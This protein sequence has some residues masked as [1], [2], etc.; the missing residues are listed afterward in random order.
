MRSP[1]PAL[2]AHPIARPMS[3]PLVTQSYS[4][5]ASLL[6][7]G[8]DGDGGDSAGD[9]GNNNML[10]DNTAMATA[11]ATP[12]MP[13][14]ASSSVIAASCNYTNVECGA[15][16]SSL[17]STS[18]LHEKVSR[19]RKLRAIITAAAAMKVQHV[20]VRIIIM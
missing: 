6:T 7:G 18:R 9:Y 14:S 17:S 1:S 13:L 8:G 12:T 19:S 15:D 10:N 2:T 4:N 3:P 5:P 11:T 16:C 20:I